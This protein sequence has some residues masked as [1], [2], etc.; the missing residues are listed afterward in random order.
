MNSM[1]WAAKP[2]IGEAIVYIADGNLRP[3][4]TKVFHRSFDGSHDIREMMQKIG[5]D[6]AGI[7]AIDGAGVTAL[8]TSGNG[9]DGV[10]ENGVTRS[11]NGYFG[12]AVETDGVSG[13]VDLGGHK[14]LGGHCAAVI[15]LDGRDP[16]HNPACQRHVRGPGALA[17]KTYRPSF[18]RQYPGLRHLRS[19]VGVFG[20]HCGDHRKNHGSG[21]DET[22][23]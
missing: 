16:S 21:V 13:N 10:L 19:G 7:E 22:Q 8:D 20:R 5:V 12:R 14:Q 18:A 4:A 11:A 3:M 9:R 23:L 6:P 2:Q 15:C 1:G 17:D